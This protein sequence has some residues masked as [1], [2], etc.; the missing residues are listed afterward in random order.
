MRRRPK[1]RRSR[2]RPGRAAPALAL[3]LVLAAGAGCTAGPGAVVAPDAGAEV[4]AGDGMPLGIPGHWHPVFRDDFSGAGLDTS[5]WSVGNPDLTVTGGDGS[6]S[7][8]PPVNTDE[9]DCYDPGQVT[10]QDGT[11]RITAVRRDETC[12]GRTLPYVSGMVHSRGKFETAYGVAEARIYLPA[13]APGVVANWPAFWQVGP[14]WPHGG[15]NDIMEGLHGQVCRYF[16]SAVASTGH[17]SDDDLTGW[18]TYAAEW[19][20]GRVD[21]YQDGVL[22]AVITQ[23]VT[24]QPQWLVLNNAVQP[25]VG[26]PTVVPAQMQVDYVRVWQP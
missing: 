23:G 22:V 15:E 4:T 24:S 8:A 7:V 21:Y 6:P 1:N 2:R 11:L 19:R 5:K 3:A 10:V 14:N 18:H 17:C 25:A 12:G 13:A 16:N 20:P 26:G 9:L